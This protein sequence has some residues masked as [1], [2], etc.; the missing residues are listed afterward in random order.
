[1]SECSVA[2]VKNYNLVTQTK[3]VCNSELEELCPSGE[4]DKGFYLNENP[5]DMLWY[6]VEDP[7]FDDMY[8]VGG[9]TNGRAGWR[10]LRGI[11]LELDISHFYWGEWILGDMVGYG[12]VQ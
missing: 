12:N 8:R 7:L 5:Q 4:I 11:P 9:W 2:T 1:M 3:P 6:S 10:T